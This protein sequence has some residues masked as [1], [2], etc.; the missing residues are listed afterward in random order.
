MVMKIRYIQNVVQLQ[1]NDI[2]IEI[3]SQ[4]SILHVVVKVLLVNNY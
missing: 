3:H 1:L 2:K 4:V